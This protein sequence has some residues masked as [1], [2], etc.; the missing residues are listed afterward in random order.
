MNSNGVKMTWMIF[1]VG[2]LCCLGVKAHIVGILR[3]SLLPILTMTDIH[4]FKNA[5]VKHNGVVGKGRRHGSAICYLRRFMG[6]VPVPGWSSS[7]HKVGVLVEDITWGFWDGGKTFHNG[8]ETLF[9]SSERK[10][11]K[12]LLDMVLLSMSTNAIIVL[13]QKHVHETI[14]CLIG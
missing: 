4:R 7:D 2:Y 6:D 13:K 5:V 11:Q 1:F 14:F 3:V 10:W 8:D 9:L 12:I